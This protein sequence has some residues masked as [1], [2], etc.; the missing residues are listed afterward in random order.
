[1][2]MNSMKP[3]CNDYSSDYTYSPNSFLLLKQAGYYQVST[4]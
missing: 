2:E 1:M 3:F 4:S